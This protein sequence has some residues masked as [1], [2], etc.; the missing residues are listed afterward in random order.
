M[1]ALLEER[2]EALADLGGLHRGRSLGTRPA[3]S[4][5]PS[6]H[7]NR[8]I[9]CALRLDVCAARESL[10][11]KL[12]RAF[13]RA[14]D[15]A[16]SRNDWHAAGRATGRGGSR[17]P[18]AAN[19]CARATRGG[20]SRAALSCRRGRGARRCV[21][22]ER[23][24]DPLLVVGLVARLR[25]GLA[26]PLRVRRL[27]RVARAAR[28]RSRPAAAARCRSCPLLVA[29]A[30]VL[31][32]APDFVA[33]AWHRGPL[34]S[35]ARRPLVLH[36]PGAR[37]S[38]RSPPASRASPTPD[39]RRSRLRPSSPATSSGASSGTAC[40][41]HAAH[42]PSVLRDLRSTRARGS[43]RSSSPLALMV[44]VAGVG[45]A[46]VL[47]AI[48]PLVWLLQR[49]RARPPGALRATRSSSTA[50]TAAP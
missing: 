8:C 26:R 25:A 42:A 49:L 5:R 24:L 19:G 29:A 46:V 38:R 37:A 39:L 36:R 14:G 35:C 18:R 43:T 1:P 23:E 21:P 3:A 48:A 17:A 27:V 22:D 7:P 44:A 4:R 12:A 33:A 30:A 41:E 31:A 16:A 9:R 20:P 6:A 34:A 45:R 13:A 50:P 2:Q 32:A 28:L 10:P 47:L 15:P 11:P 40:C